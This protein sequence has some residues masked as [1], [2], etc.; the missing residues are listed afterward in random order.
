M[1]EELAS[2]HIN[3]AIQ[4]L[5]KADAVLGFRLDKQIE[6]GQLRDLTAK[7]YKFRD[8]FAKAGI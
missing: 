4:Y 7:L 8:D 5:L 3:E 6:L 1:D 2:E